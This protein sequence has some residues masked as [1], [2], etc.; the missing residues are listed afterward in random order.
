MDSHSGLDYPNLAVCKVR[1]QGGAARLRVVLLPKNVR[2]AANAMDI[3]A[4]PYD[5]SLGAY[6][7]C[8]V[9]N[10]D[11]VGV[12]ASFIYRTGSKGNSFQSA[13]S[14]NAFYLL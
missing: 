7:F 9:I 2:E 14:L 6:W 13:S 5:F 10:I 12:A 1:L 8:M 4:T 11:S 3:D